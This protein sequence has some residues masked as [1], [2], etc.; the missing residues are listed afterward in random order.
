MEY[1]DGALNKM[2]ECITMIE[3]Q[4]QLKLLSA[5]DWPNMKKPQRTKYHKEIY[6]QAFPDAMRTKKY[7]S[8]KDL[9]RVL[10]K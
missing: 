9:L 8:P 7:I 10:G 2:W 6:S 4:E 3:A 5:L 1:P